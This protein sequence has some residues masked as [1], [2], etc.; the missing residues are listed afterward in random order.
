MG[1]ITRFSR[2]PADLAGARRLAGQA[3]LPGMVN[4]HSHAFHRVLRGRAEQRPRP[5]RDTAMPWREV[6]DQALQRL[7]A[8]DVFDSA[9]MAFLEMLLGGITCVA[10]FHYLHHQPD[11]S[12]AAD[13]NR[14]SR[15]IL[16][17]AHDVGV[18]IA[19]LK[20]AYARGDFGGD[21]ASAPPRARTSSTDQFVRECEQLRTFVES[22][23]P[24]DEAWLGVAAHS[25]GAV[26]LPIFREIGGY[27]H[28]RRL[29]L[30]AHVSAS[31][32]ENA[33]CVAE[34]GRTPI[35]L[36]AEHGLIDKR[37]TAVGAI[38]LAEDE[39][40]LMGAARASVCVCPVSERS[41]GFGTAPV[42]EL[43]AAGAGIALGTDRQVQ[44]GLL[45]NARLLEYELRSRVPTRPGGT[46]PAA[47]WWHAA[48]V[49]GARSLGATTGALEV[50]RPADFFTV[51]LFDPALAGAA[52]ENLLAAIVLGLERRAIREVWVGA[53]PIITGGRHAFQGP[54][55]GRFADL[56]KRLWG[57]AGP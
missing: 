14:Y 26:P 32:A 19:L 44:G 42:E 16:R 48:T 54:I 50:G 41:H 3:A 25:L 13:P 11:G 8:E 20:V 51:N 1:R 9:R 17:A 53:R 10:E 56:Q 28:S 46:D 29:R 4:A 34:Y 30:H 47:A 39:I 31:A 2:E 35:A 40:K 57:P 33:A 7:T 49:A 45:E 22:E 5:D 52:P 6:H 55:V 37:F 18:R 15:E 21:A 27:A 36:L 38:H 43:L 12:P 23:Y 24:A